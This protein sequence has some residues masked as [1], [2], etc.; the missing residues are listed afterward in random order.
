MSTVSAGGNHHALVMTN[1][2]Q[3]RARE[4]DEPMPTMTTAT[5]GG[6]GLVA[7]EPFILD[8]RGEYRIRP[9]E[10]PL[11]TITANDTTKALIQDS[12]FDPAALVHRHNTGGAEMSTPASEYLRTLT[13]GGNVSLLRPPR[14]TVTAADLRAAEDMLPEVLFRM[15]RPHEV[16]VGM[17]FPGDYDW[18]TAVDEKGRPA[19]NRDLVKMAGNAVTPPASRDL[20]GMAVEYITGRTVD[21]PGWD[22][23]AV[24]A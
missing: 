5:G 16:A 13:A 3:N 12:L 18:T 21:L 24:A 6:S 1:Q 19:T 8:R 22:R 20:I 11:S 4:I 10:R 17:A 2:R 14:R 7:R 9:L 23:W 15:F